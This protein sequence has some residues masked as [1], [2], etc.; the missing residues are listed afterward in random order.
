MFMRFFK[1]QFNVILILLVSMMFPPLSSGLA[2]YTAGNTAA[3]LAAKIQGKGITITNPV[4]RRGGSQATAIFSNGVTGA[5]L[6]I[7]EGIYLGGMFADTAFT[8]NTSGSTSNN[9]PDI[10]PDPD[11]VAIDARATNDTVVFEFD[12]TLES[13][14]KLLLINYQF[15]SDEYNEY[16]GSIYN[17][18]FGFFISGGDLPAG[19]TYNIA[20]VVD[21]QVFTDIVTLQNFPP[22]TVNNVN[23]G[24]RG[25]QDSGQPADLTNSQY[26]IDNTVNPNPVNVEF[27]GLTVGLNATLDNLTGGMTYHV[28]MALADVG[29]SLWDTG[30]FV[31]GIQ[32]IRGPQICYDYAYKQNGRFFTEEYGAGSPSLDGS[33]VPGTPVSIRVTVQNRHE[34]EILA[35]DV[36]FSVLNMDTTQIEYEPGTVY[37]TNPGS[38]APVHISDNTLGMTNQPDEILN[39]PLDDLGSFENFFVYYDV[40][41]KKSALNTP[42]KMRV[43]YNITLPLSSTQTLKYHLAEILDKDTPICTG[44]NFE[45]T[46]K[47]GSFNVEDHALTQDGNGIYNLFTQVAKR[48]FD[49]D[50]VSYSLANLHTQQGVNTAVALELIDAKPYH[51]VNSSCE[52]P[53]SAFTK[54]YWMVLGDGTAIPSPVT[55]IN[56]PELIE[57]GEARENVA[58]RISYNLM[59][60]DGSLMEFGEPDATGKRSIKN[61][62][63]GALI[64]AKPNCETPVSRP[65]AADITTTVVACGDGN[66]LT[67]LQISQCMECLYGY[68]TI[69]VCSRDNFSIRPEAFDIKIYDDKQGTSG[70]KTELPEVSNTAAGYSYGYDFIATSHIDENPVAGYTQGFLTPFVDH[71]ISNRWSPTGTVSG[72]NDIADKYLKGYLVNGL[73]AKEYNR[74]NNVGEY[75]LVMTDSSW[76]MVDQIASHHVGVHYNDKDCVVGESFVPSVTTVLNSTNVG[77]TISSVHTNVD[78]NKY[79]EHN[80]TVHPYKF[81]LDEV[82]YSTTNPN[83]LFIYVNTLGFGANND[84]NMSINLVGEIKAQGAD[85]SVLDNFVTDCYAKNLKLTLDSNTSPVTPK[86]IDG[87]PVQFRWLENS[88][89]GGNNTDLFTN[90]AFVKLVDSEFSKIFGGMTLL[91]LYVNF[92]RKSNTVM[93]PFAFELESLDVA[94][95][96]KKECR[97]YANGKKKFNP[98]GNKVYD[99][100]VTVLYGR[101]NAPRRIVMCDS[102]LVGSGCVGVMDF[103]YE[104]YADTNAN[105]AL[106]NNL[107]GPNPQRSSNSVNWYKNTVHA[108]SDGEVKLT[109]QSNISSSAP[110][111]NNGVTQITYTYNGDK[112]YPFKESLNITTGTGVEPWLIYDKYNAAATQTSAHLEFYGPGK[113]TSTSGSNTTHSTKANEKK[114]TNRRIQW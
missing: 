87:Q 103:Y 99:Q 82:K 13:N 96:K 106:I 10:T 54:R 43:D 75:S 79:K 94:C 78:R 34:N 39:I 29:D 101:V 93:N 46:P 70:T 52:D 27:D 95:K 65:P 90:K 31:N 63:F 83:D 48:P 61:L 114:K 77:C 86:D 107:V 53:L 100:N 21:P 88:A 15:A 19:T 50:V 49:V 36:Q 28:K 58:F 109:T 76:T 111:T 80:T 38:L 59:P 30:V 112:G 104:F 68:D 20:R 97:S 6:A 57:Q 98:K 92:E 41:P 42:L 60:D 33:V 40:D 51:D 2:T 25:S 3:E 17:D 11:L 8:L 74:H 89:S 24:T 102:G 14:V 105:P 37:V 45:Y 16:V 66:D 22:V 47:Y 81:G 84:S 72:C 35:E 113:W 23:N 73:A 71:N 26:F 85:N 91:K 7:D 44:A 1:K 110:T 5:N 56:I 64:A 62:D 69:S 9:F 4:I 67:P 32:G 12:V 18:A 108:V 55:E